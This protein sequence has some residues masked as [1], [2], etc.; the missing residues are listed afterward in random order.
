MVYLDVVWGSCLWSGELAS[1]ITVR[2][3]ECVFG[4][5]LLKAITG[6]TGK[7]EIFFVFV[8]PF[9]CGRIGHGHDVCFFLD[10]GLC[11]AYPSL[12][13]CGKGGRVDLDR[14]VAPSL[15]HAC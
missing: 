3:R 8:F 13:V 1:R 7:W 4:D 10:S 9:S 5:L 6:K 15:R 2:C 14:S 11:R 12:F